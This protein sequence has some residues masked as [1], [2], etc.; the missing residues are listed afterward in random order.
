MRKAK[1]KATKKKAT[2]KV[3]RKKPSK[4]RKGA[5]LWSAADVSTLRKMY[6]SNTNTVIARK[7]RRSVGSVA[8]KARSLGLKKPVRKAA[9]KKAAPKRKAAKR[10]PAKKKAAKRKPA[11]KKAAKKRKR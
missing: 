3:A 5:K 6:K 10:R 4:T 8:A 7:L 11:K 9:K 2:K 1:K